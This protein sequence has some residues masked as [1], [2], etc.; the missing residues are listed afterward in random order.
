MES[1]RIR[2]RLSTVEE[3]ERRCEET[4]NDFILTGD[5]QKDWGVQFTNP[6]MQLVWGVIMQ[7]ARDETLPKAE[8]EEQLRVML[9]DLV[10][11]S[12]TLETGLSDDLIYEQLVD[13]YG[14]F[15][16]S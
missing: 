12:N 11:Q 5:P 9:G 14:P 3:L 10:D 2:A 8:H 6:M 16:R 15:P 4:S 13:L 7:R 1:L